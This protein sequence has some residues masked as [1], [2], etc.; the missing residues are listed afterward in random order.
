MKFNNVKHLYSKLALKHHII[1]MKRN[2][3]GVK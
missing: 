1:E 3:D 2:R